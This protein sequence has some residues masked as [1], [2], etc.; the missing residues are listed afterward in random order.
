MKKRN[1]LFSAMIGIS[2]ALHGAAFFLLSL[3]PGNPP[4]AE[5]ERPGETLSLVNIA[6]IEPAAPD[7]V[8][9]TPLPPPP[10]VP[11]PPAPE[12]PADLPAENYIPTDEIPADAPLPFPAE[13]PAVITPAF[14]PAARAGPPSGGT[15]DNA[16]LTAAYVK[17]N[18]D[19]IQRRIRDRLAYPAQARRAGIQGTAELAF[20][21]HEDG[22]VSDVKIV[23]S[24]GSDLLDAAAVE[25]IHAASPF[26]PPPTP[27]RLSIPV[28]FRLR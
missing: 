5:P 14:Q 21:I 6:L 2:L 19:Y 15:P 10:P 28:A 4:A 3:Y 18:Y 23:I 27:A 1:G 12:I 24:S 26:K 25:S 13:T 7:P 22:R 17:R 8:P 20:T 11:P 9:P 16:A